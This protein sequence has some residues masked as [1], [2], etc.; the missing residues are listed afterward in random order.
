[1]KKIYNKLVR[2]KIPEI[3][4]ANG[5]EPE[6]RILPQKEY[7]LEL[8]KKLAEEVAEYRTDGTLEELADILELVIANA[9]ANGDSLAA[10]EKI[11]LKKAEQRGRFKKRIFL[12]ATVEDRIK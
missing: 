10:L 11:R 4:R 6:I 3:C 7:R 5:A 9:E 2:D 8:R 1:M 12:I